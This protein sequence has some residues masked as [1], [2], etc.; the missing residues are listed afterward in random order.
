MIHG[1]HRNCP[2]VA[3]IM[4]WATHR[5][6]TRVEDRA[7]L[8]IIGS[9]GREYADGVWRGNKSILPSSAGDH[10]TTK[11]SLRREVSTAVFDV[12]KCGFFIG[13]QVDMTIYS[14]NRRSCL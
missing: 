8:L 14:G 5:K 13:T 12:D 4:S 7:Y 2:Y 11:A 1:L 6:S 10:R 9:A 3:Q